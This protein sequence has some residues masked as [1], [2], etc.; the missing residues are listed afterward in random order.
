MAAKRS[1]HSQHEKE[2]TLLGFTETVLV[3][4]KRSRHS[5]LQRTDTSS[6]PRNYYSNS[7][8][9][10]GT[11]RNPTRKLVGLLNWNPTRKLVCFHRNPAVIHFVILNRYLPC[12]A[13]CTSNPTRK[14]VWIT[15]TVSYTRYVPVQ[16]SKMD[17]RG[18]PGARHGT[19]GITVHNQNNSRQRK[20]D[21]EQLL[22]ENRYIVRTKE[23]LQQSL[24]YCWH[25]IS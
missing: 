12:V 16:Y 15:G 17:Y 21:S 3:A 7:S 1:R 5:Q 13:Y 10:V 18:I 2:K 24:W 20:F 4:A 23:L 11:H 22:L 14:L 9:S 25:A 8:G 6:E 19:R